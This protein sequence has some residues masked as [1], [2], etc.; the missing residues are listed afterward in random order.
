MLG[1]ITEETIILV[2]AVGVIEDNHTVEMMEQLIFWYGRD[3]RGENIVKIQNTHQVEMGNINKFV[4][5]VKMVTTKLVEWAGKVID[6]VV[7][8]TGR[9]VDTEWAMF[10]VYKVESVEVMVDILGSCRSF[11]PTSV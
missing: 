7:Y 10:M 8:I 2:N 11:S 1:Y 4:E 3:T 6:K 5:W 9:E